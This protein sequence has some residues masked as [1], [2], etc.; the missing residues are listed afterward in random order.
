M[1]AGEVN[2]IFKKPIDFPQL[3]CFL[4]TIYEYCGKNSSQST[5]G[6]TLCL[7]AWAI[8]HLCLDLSIIS[9]RIILLHVSVR[10]KMDYYINKKGE[11]LLFWLVFSVELEK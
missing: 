6:F 1:T 7:T 4:K 10:I 5:S 2:E 3:Q 8:H 9:S 11:F